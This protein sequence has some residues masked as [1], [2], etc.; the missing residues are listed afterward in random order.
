MLVARRIQLPAFGLQYFTPASIIL[1]PSVATT[2]PQTVQKSLQTSILF[3]IQ[4]KLI[5]YIHKLGLVL[6]SSP[7]LLFLSI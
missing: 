4:K 2:L 7:L 3:V 5:R 6:S 1:N